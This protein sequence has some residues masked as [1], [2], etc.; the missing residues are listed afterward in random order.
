[1]GT[2]EC[3]AMLLAG[4]QGNRLGILTKDLA[5][6]AVPFG[7]KY[8]IIDFTLS[9]CT[10]SGIDTVGVL[11]QYEPLKLHSY[12]GIGQPWD[13]DRLVGGISILPPYTSGKRGEWYSGTAN[14]VYQNLRFI[15]QYDPAYVLVLSGDHVYKMDYS[16][17]L[18]YH[19]DNGASVTIAVIKVPME[20]ASRFGI[21]TTRSDGRIER[22]DEKPEK[23]E[24]NL[25]SMGVYIF[26]WSVLRT[27]LIEDAGM[28]S[29]SHDFGKDVI[30]RMLSMGER[31]YAYRFNG[32]WKDVGTVESLWEAHMDLLAEPPLFDLYDPS[33]RIY[34]RNPVEPP[35]YIAPTAQVK[36]SIVSEGSVVYGQVEHSVIFHGVYIGPNTIVRDSVI[37]PYAE[38]EA[39]VELY[40]AIVAEQAVVTQNSA[41]EGGDGK[42]GAISVYSSLALTRNYTA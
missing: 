22:F 4:G 37:M 28:E 10:N 41:A 8:R 42:A 12:L 34:A 13:L 25:A 40:K 23:P 38:I 1:V 32:Y 11:T 26:N 30:P 5:K 9:N 24:S 17:M 19:R 21:M 31:M 35:H 36:G 20:E 6:P 29:S 2:K 39:G 7:G 3:V 18:A 15:M 33:W 16:K 14:A 27:Y